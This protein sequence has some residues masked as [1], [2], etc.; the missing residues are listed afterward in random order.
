MPD[1]VRISRI[2]LEKFHEKHPSVTNVL[3]LLRYP[4]VITYIVQAFQ[5]EAN[6]LI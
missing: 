5:L 2:S 3:V 4:D 6:R 1:Q